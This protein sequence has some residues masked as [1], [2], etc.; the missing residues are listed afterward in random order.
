VRMAGAQAA[1]RA[2]VGIDFVEKAGQAGL[3]AEPTRRS[4]TASLPWLPN[5]AM[6]LGNPRFK[7]LI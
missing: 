4:S 3:M 6:N 2:R 1:G 7:P 5:S